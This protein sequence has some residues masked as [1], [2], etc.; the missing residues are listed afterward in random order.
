MRRLQ[1]GIFAAA[2]VGVAALLNGLINGFGLGSGTEGTPGQNSEEQ[3]AQEEPDESS[4]E[5]ATDESPEVGSE[6]PVE[7]LIDEREFLVRASSGSGWS[8]ISVDALVKAIADSKSDDG[9]KAKVFRTPGARASAEEELQSALD[10][11]GV[12]TTTVVVADELIERDGAS[13]E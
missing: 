13:S 2:V 9:I 11:A 3:T 5:T 4:E 8:P 1:I 10:D 6:G 7:I 12:D